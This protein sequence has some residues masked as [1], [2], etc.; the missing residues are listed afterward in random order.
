M[1]LLIA[2]R[3]H[4]LLSPTHQGSWSNRPKVARRWFVKIEET[5]SGKVYLRD[6]LSLSR[7]TIKNLKIF[8]RFPKVINLFDYRVR[9]IGKEYRLQY[10]RGESQLLR[11]EVIVFKKVVL[12]HNKDGQFVAMALHINGKLLVWKMG[13]DRW[14][15]IDDG[16]QY[17]KD[18]AY[19]K[20]RF[21]VVDDTRRIIAVDCSSLEITQVAP[22]APQDAH[23]TF[24]YLVKSQDDLY[25]IYRYGCSCLNVFKLD[26]ELGKW[27]SNGSWLSDWVMFVG[28]GGFSCSFLAA[29]FG[30]RK[31]NRIYIR[32]SCFTSVKTDG[33]FEYNEALSL[34]RLSLYS[35]F[36]WPPPT[37][38]KQTDQALEISER[39]GRD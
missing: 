24:T 28:D 3:K 30:R 19:H 6:P 34:K 32:D 18:I 17:Y 2:Q 15:G 35:K 37:W 16:F 1:P 26:E 29:E 39:T 11:E 27:D 25:L 13:E 31:G 22:S 12:G 10:V 14:V 5:E 21:Y 4:H 36:F 20:G 8:T 9:E 7:M 38:L 23:R 33:K